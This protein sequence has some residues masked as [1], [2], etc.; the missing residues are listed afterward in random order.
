MEATIVTTRD[1]IVTIVN[2][3]DDERFN[4]VAMYVESVIKKGK[5]RTR[6][7]VDALMKKHSA[8][9]EKAFHTLTEEQALDE[10]E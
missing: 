9:Y 7:E 4:K 3:L 2:S 10:K 1:E 5:F 8:E 6:E